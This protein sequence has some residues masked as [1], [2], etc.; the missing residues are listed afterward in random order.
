M[1][2][3]GW[4]DAEN[5]FGAL[6]VYRNLLKN[7]PATDNR[8]VVGPWVHGG[9]SRGDGSKL[10]DVQFNAP[11][12]EFYREKIEFP[13]FEHFLK[14]VSSYEH[15]K[16]WVFETGTNVWRKYEDWPPRQ[17]QTHAY[18]LSAGGKLATEAPSQAGP[19][20]ADEYLSD[21]ARPVNYQETTTT[22]MTQEYMTADQRFASR[23]PDV[24]VY[25]TPVL[26]NDVTV[27]GPIKVNLNVS[28]TGTDSD[29]VVKLIDV[30]PNDF[31]DPTPNPTGVRMGGYQQLVRGDVFRGKF[32]NS[33]EKPEPFEPGK[34]AT[35]KFNMQDVCHT[36][37]T[38][39]RI[40]VQ[41]QSSWFPLIDRNP[42][43]FVDIYSAPASDYQKA[44]ERV[45][46][47]HDRPSSVTLL[48]MP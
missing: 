41:V 35:I 26:D 8:I 34:P 33:F 44:T 9:W 4:Y 36:F 17:A 7:S 46:H 15:P 42:Q 19:N 31:A 25:E 43:K 38:G 45:Y 29:W 32:R 40:M 1:T 3:G 23:R 30:Y 24:L 10:G 18:Y 13:F 11:T 21:P 22:R 16:A 2:V 12:S 6:E 28:T 48:V 39:H 37:R 5:L 47:T 20:E 14:G 27:A